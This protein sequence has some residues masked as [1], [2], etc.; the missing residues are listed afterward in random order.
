M[1]ALGEVA[2]NPGLQLLAL[3]CAT[4]VLS[5]AANWFLARVFVGKTYRYLI[6][7]GVIVH[8]Y[9]HALACIL[10]GARIRKVRVFKETGGEVVHEP[11][12]LPFGEGL[13]SVAP[14]L[15][16]AIAVYLLAVLLVPGFVGL[17][18]LEISSW[19][20][21]AFAYLAS[22]VTAAMAPS[23]QDLRAGLAAFV[24]ICTIIGLGALLPLASDYFDALLGTEFERIRGLVLF[25]LIVLATLT[26]AAAAAYAVLQRTTRQGVTYVT[27]GSTPAPRKP[28]RRRVSGRLRKDKGGGLFE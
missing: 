1:E 4:L 18:E 2:A 10:T 11:A 19:Q 27:Q 20:F 15:G 3:L 17:G 7:P 26:A 24:V 5:Y 13:I 25:S 8:E 6:A 12:R 28:S 16:A 9:S 21:L 22:S 14:I 23:M